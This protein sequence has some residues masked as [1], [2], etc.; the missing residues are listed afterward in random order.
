MAKSSGVIGTS[1]C[2]GMGL[3][4][5]LTQRSSSLHGMSH[6][7]VRSICDDREG[8]AVGWSLGEVARTSLLRPAREV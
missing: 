5:N 8:R 7:G 4:Y 2:L 3:Y 6:N 1:L